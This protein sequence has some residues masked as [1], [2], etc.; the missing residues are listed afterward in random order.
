MGFSAGSAA[1]IRELN[2]AREHPERY[3]QYLEER[4]AHFRGNDLVLPGRTMLHTREGVGAVDEAIR[5]LRHT[6]PVASLIPS[7]GIARA[8]A[9]HVADQASGSMGHGGSDFSNAGDRMNRHGTWD[10]LW[11]ENISY[12]KTTARDV[13]L[14]LIID[15]GLRSRKHRKNIFN[16][17]FKYAGVAVGRH[18][19][20]RVVCSIDFAAGYVEA[21]AGSRSLVAGN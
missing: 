11:G 17:A 19:R 8:A 4:R 10:T 2:L 20:Y 6:R 13:V 1:V 5:F 12:G 7:P 9:E 3:A 16:S 18:A 15:D 14:T 21:G